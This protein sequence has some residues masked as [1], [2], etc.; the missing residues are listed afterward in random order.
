MAAMAAMRHQPAYDTADAAE[1][2]HTPARHMPPALPCLINPPT[3]SPCLINQPTLSPCLINQP[4]HPLPLPHQPT[5]P[6]PL[7][8]CPPARYAV[9]TV[10]KR[11]VQGFLE[12]KFVDRVQREVDI[13]RHL[14]QSLNVAHLYE[15][16]EDESCVDMVLQLCTGGWWPWCCSCATWRRAAAAAVQVGHVPC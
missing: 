2:H 1:T 12:C 5:N 3:L 4:T 15:A 10:P 14:G 7:P 16:Y 11:F 6:L 8:T 9:K 13:Y